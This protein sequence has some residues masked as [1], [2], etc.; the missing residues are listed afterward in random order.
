MLLLLLLWIK[1]LKLRFWFIQFHLLS[2]LRIECSSY[3]ILSDGDRSQNYLYQ[4]VQGAK[5]TCDLWL[6][7]NWYR[8]TGLAGDRMPEKCVPTRRCGTL[9]PGWLQGS[10][11]SARDGVVQR[12]VCFNWGRTCCMW[13]RKILVRNC[14][15]FYVYKLQNAPTC[16]LRY[17]GVGQNTGKVVKLVDWSWKVHV[18]VIIVTCYPT[19][20][21]LFHQMLGKERFSVRNNIFV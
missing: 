13:R 18:P 7:K 8:F 21:Y 12:T 16:K 10:H 15:D 20:E 2:Y 6:R 19:G 14:G 5:P 9:A 17:C 3:R 11:P 4:S 1:V